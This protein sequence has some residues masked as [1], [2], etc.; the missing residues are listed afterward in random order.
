[1]IP[2]PKCGKLASESASRSYCCPNCGHP[3][4]LKKWQYEEEMKKKESEARK[5]AQSKGEVFDPAIWR[6]EEEKKQRAAQREREI[7]WEREREEREREREI[8][9]ERELAEAEARASVMRQELERK[10][11]PGMPD[12]ITTTSLFY[13]E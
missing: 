3:F 7:K 6:Y 1:M 11:D 10:N 9:R 8:K 13:S 5:Q 2:C 4:D 12:Y